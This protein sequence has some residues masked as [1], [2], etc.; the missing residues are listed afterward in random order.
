MKRSSLRFLFVSFITIISLT[1]CDRE[2]TVCTPEVGTPK[3]TLQL[4]ELIKIAATPGPT[5]VPVLVEISGGIIEVDKLVDYPI[6]NDDWYGT[7]YVNCDAQVAMWDPE[8]GSRFFEGCNL[9]ID[10]NAVVYVAAHNDSPHYKGCSCHT[11]EV[12]EIINP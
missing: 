4:A 11:G 8:E 9:N 10:P 6:C 1:A 12:Y 3:P 2:K 5:P 7:V